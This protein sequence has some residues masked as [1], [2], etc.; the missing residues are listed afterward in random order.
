MTRRAFLLPAGWPPSHL[1]SYRDWRILSKKR[2]KS[3]GEIVANFSV[4]KPCINLVGN[5]DF[6]I[7]QSHWFHESLFSIHVFHTCSETVYHPARSV[8][9]SYQDFSQTLKKP[10]STNAEY[11]K[12]HVVHSHTRCL[13][14]PTATPTPIPI[15]YMPAKCV[16]AAPSAA[17]NVPPPVPAAVPYIGQFV[18]CR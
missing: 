2:G 12:S 7:I 5:L 13:A 15:P 9:T 16:G 1:L 8:N 3:P 4:L 6:S 10:T 14:I 11:S 17:S 18:N